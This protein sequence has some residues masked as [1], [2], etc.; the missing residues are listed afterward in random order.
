MQ[1]AEL[2]L[3]ILKDKS[4]K[5]PNYRFQRIYRYLFNID[6]YLRAYSQVYSNEN[7]RYTIEEEV[8]KFSIESTY[9]VIKKLKNE[10]YYP[11]P[12]KKTDKENKKHWKTK[13]LYDNLIQQIIVEI[14]QAIYNIDFSIN[15][16]G[17]IPN[18]TYHNALYKIKS[19]CGGSRWVIRG[20][21]ENYFY[22]INY[23]FLIE[24]LGEKIS[25]GR[26]INLIYKFLVAGYMKEKK[27][28]DTLSEIS[29]RKSLASILINIYLYKFDKYM[30][31]EFRQAE[32]TRYL[33]NFII[34]TF[35]NRDLSE[36]MVSD[37]ISFLQDKL[38]IK[39]TEKEIFMIDLNKR[40][41]RFLGYEIAKLKC[42]YNDN[43]N[44]KHEEKRDSGIIQ[45]LIPADVIRKRIKPLMLNGKSIHNS[46]R[47]NLPIFKIISLYN[48][49]IIEL[50]NY[51]SLASDVNIKIRKFKFYHYLS[52]VKTLARKEQIS[53]KQVL[54]RYGI[55]SKE[56]DKKIVGVSYNTENGIKTVTYFNESLKKRNKPLYNINDI[57]GK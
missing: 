13:T 5:N 39:V 47:I 3:A 26:F 57:I 32:Y 33:D 25:D 38:N 12:L 35:E 22:N 14:L 10:S 31:E 49:E 54:N 50:Y 9:E 23:D 53:V 34:F 42:N 41:A 17:F 40:R 6:F 8:H 56:K 11:E 46:S 1:K 24:L 51:Y 19:T 16:H 30:N 45:L 18:K 28:C 37:V 21:I 43:K 7:I 48:R 27:D 2:I 29:H 20:N 52:L 44:C 36:Y 15:S 4:N 55:V